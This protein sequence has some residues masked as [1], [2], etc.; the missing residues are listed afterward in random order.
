MGNIIDF[1]RDGREAVTCRKRWEDA[2]FGRGLGQRTRE[3]GEFGTIRWA[4]DS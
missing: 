1:I 2:D 3:D 4:S